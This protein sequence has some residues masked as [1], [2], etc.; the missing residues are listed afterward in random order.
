MGDAEIVENLRV[1]F[2]SYWALLAAVICILGIIAFINPA[3]Q[4]ILQNV[5]VVG[6]ERT[7][8]LRQAREQFRHGSKNMLLE[9]YRKVFHFIFNNG[10]SYIFSVQREAFLCSDQV[11]RTTHDPCQICGGA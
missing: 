9:G 8:T 11:G 1:Y 3:R 6:L 10:F 2:K 5:P 7:K 4:R